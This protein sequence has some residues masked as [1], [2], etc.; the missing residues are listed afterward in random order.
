MSNKSCEIKRTSI[1]GQALIEGVM[2]R[3][4]HKTSMAVRHTSG[5]IVMDSWERE[6]GT[7]TA[8]FW[9]TPFVRGIFNFI[10]SL[11]IG[12]RCLMKSVDMSGLGD[13]EE[14]EQRLKEEKKAAKK[15]A[16]LKKKY[17]DEYKDH[18]DAEDK[19]DDEEIKT[20]KL[21]DSILYSVIMI[22]SSVLGIGLGIILFMWLP[23]YLY[24]FLKNLSPVFENRFLQSFCEG[25]LRIAIFI[26]YISMTAFMKDIRRVYQYHGAEHKTIFCYEHGNEL[27]V[28]NVRKESRFHPRCGTSFMILMLLVG[29]FISM[30]IPNNIAAWIRASIKILLLP[31]VMG[32]GYE[33]IKLAGRK[34]NWFTKAISKPGMW[35]QRITTK[36]PED[37]MIECAIAAFKDVIPENEDEDKW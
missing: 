26:A 22:I 27:T 33:A 9:K 28:E 7:H 1:G 15:E 37:D 29:I 30:L 21:S 32:I 3:G 10:D 20:K 6:E 2:M 14:E 5:N 24:N 17:G 23:I 11:V 35:V 13:E 31:I 8:F 16:K 12:Y 4:P 19:K 18:I 36:E 25:L 34:D